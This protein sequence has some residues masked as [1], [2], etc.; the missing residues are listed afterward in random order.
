MAAA[1]FLERDFD[2]TVPERTMNAPRSP[3][4]HVPGPASMPSRELG[5]LL[6][7]LLETERAGARLLTA[8]LNELT[9]EADAWAPLCAIQRDEARNCGVLIDLLREMGFEP[10]MATGDFY[11]KATTAEGWRKRL[12]IFNLGQRQVAA[13][14]AAA[15]SRIPPSRGKDALQA[16]HDSHH[17][18]IAVCEELLQ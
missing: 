4:H 1:G 8:Y 17:A 3:A 9:P 10:S 13:R 7:L 6:N 14:I 16:M 11:H 18:N 5:S 15:S 12:E 2:M